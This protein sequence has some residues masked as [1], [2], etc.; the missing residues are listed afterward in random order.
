MAIKCFPTLMTK[1]MKYF[2]TEQFM[3]QNPNQA[4]CEVKESN[5]DL[6]NKHQHDT[7]NYTNLAHIMKMETLLTLKLLSFS[8]MTLT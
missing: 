8:R 1:A 6:E 3:I 5:R 2:V 4:L 7:V